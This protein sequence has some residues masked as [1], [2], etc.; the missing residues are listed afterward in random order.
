MKSRICFGLQWQKFR[1]CNP[2]YSCENVQCNQ[3][4]T[5]HCTFGPKGQKIPPGKK[6]FSQ[7]SEDAWTNELEW[8]SAPLYL[9]QVELWRTSF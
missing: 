4:Q 5:N 3:N 9:L 8:R 7:T 1:H 2:N 6:Q